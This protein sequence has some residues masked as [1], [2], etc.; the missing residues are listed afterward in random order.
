MTMLNIDDDPNNQ[1]KFIFHTVDVVR[2]AEHEFCSSEDS[3]G[4]RK[5]E[6]KNS[7]YLLAFD[8]CDALRCYVCDE[9]VGWV[10]DDSDTYHNAKLHFTDFYQLD[11]GA[12]CL[13]CVP[14]YENTIQS[15]RNGE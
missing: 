4:D 7:V 12:E 3:N 2:E 15:E 14:C 10:L 1:E 13:M 8:N 5:Y 9:S 11:T 6:S